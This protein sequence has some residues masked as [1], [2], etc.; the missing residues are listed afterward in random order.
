MKSD[1][2]RPGLQAASCCVGVALA[3]L[4]SSFYLKPLDAGAPWSFEAYYL[5]QAV[6][7]VLTAALGR[8]CG[9]ARVRAGRLACALSSAC[10]LAAPVLAIV[11]GRLPGMPQAWLVTAGLMGGA[12]WAWWLCSFFS[13]ATRLPFPDMSAA[14]LLA[15]AAFPLLRLPLEFVPLPWAVAACSAVPLALLPLLKRAEAGETPGGHAARRAGSRAG[16]VLVVAE[17]V[18]FGAVMGLFRVNADT[19]HA[20]VGVVV[21][22]LAVKAL[23]PAALLLFVRRAQTQ[24]RLGL[25]CQ[26]ALMLI[27]IAI[28]IAVNLRTDALL[29]YALFDCMRELLYV[30]LFF[31]LAGLAGQTRMRAGAVFALGWGAYVC[32]LGAGMFAGH[33]LGGL[34]SYPEWLVVSVMCLLA[35]VSVI[36]S[37][38]RDNPDIRL[39]A[40]GSPEFV[41]PLDTFADI[42]ARCEAIAARVGLTRRELEVM[43]LICKGRSKRYIAEKFVISENTVRT[44]AKQLYAKL[45]VHSRQELLT[46]VERE[47]TR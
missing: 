5:S 39:F 2:R 12:A 45:D 21:V 35:C 19:T 14:I 47:S 1:V 28:T 27:L 22:S 36:A 32:A 8:A 16:L 44:Y 6:A 25:L 31:A 24:A 18:A 13:A 9:D 7:L 4:W 23:A 30:L 11:A 42:D 41:P 40:D 33:A 34:A 20:S 10:M 26:L 46:L 3:F 37:N 15:L 17:V 38:F 29:A 43:Q